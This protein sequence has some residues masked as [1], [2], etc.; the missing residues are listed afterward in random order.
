[1]L[2]SYEFELHKDLPCYTIAYCNPRTILTYRVQANVWNLLSR[3]VILTSARYD[4]KQGV[5]G[6]RGEPSRSAQWS[7]A[8]GKAPPRGRF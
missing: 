4:P 1:M 2:N 5:F 6:F 8:Q 3:C 7:P